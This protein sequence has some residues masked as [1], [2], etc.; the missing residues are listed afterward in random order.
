MIRLR[1]QRHLSGPTSTIGS[2]H[3]VEPDMSLSDRW[4]Y[5]CEDVV[6][7]RPGAPVS[8]WKIP[9]K[10]AIPSGVYQ[11]R[12]THS[13]KFNR[14]LPELLDVPG[15]VGIRIH[16]GN[17]SG[18]TEGCILPGLETD[19]VNVFKSRLAYG[20]IAARLEDWFD[21]GEQVFLEVRNP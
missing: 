17:S 6:R 7:E 19:G 11:I 8:E 12:F 13:P 2:L 1:L 14:E 10:T 18:D 4:C 21:Q 15:F 20:M 9:G 16:P 3:E 5:T